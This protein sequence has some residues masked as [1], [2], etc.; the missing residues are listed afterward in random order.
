MAKLDHMQD[1]IDVALGIWLCVSP[2]VLSFPDDIKLAAWIVIAVG[3]V[4]ILVSTAA[5]AFPDPIEE[6]SNI[7]LGVALMVSPWALGYSDHQV[8]TAS[9]FVS[10]LLITGFATWALEHMTH[11]LSRM[12]GR[13]KTS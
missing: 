5:V 10:G 1:W 13:Q 4:V 7:V 12:L 9:T 6:W 8:A 2:W 11:L 3:A